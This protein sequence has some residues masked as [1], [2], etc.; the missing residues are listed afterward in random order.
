MWGVQALA[1]AL[2]A[3]A[4]RFAQ[5]APAQRLAEALAPTLCDGV[6]GARAA[7]AAAGHGGAAPPADGGEGKGLGGARWFGAA[8]NSLGA[9]A[10][11]GLGGPPGGSEAAQAAPLAPK[12]RVRHPGERGEKTADGRPKPDERT[13]AYLVRP[14]WFETEDEVVALLTRGKLQAA[15]YP[16]ET[17]EPAAD[18]LESTL[19]PEPVVKGLCPAARAVKTYPFLLTR[20]MAT[21]QRNWDALKLPIEQGG[22]GMMLSEEQAREAV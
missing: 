10:E 1:A 4:P 17:A 9:A 3:R 5:R 13:V 6:W 20:D 14:G 18:W 15:R 12:R 11:R 16:F 8:A 2:R 19:G 7:S 22:V 21:L